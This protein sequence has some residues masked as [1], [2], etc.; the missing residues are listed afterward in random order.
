MAVKRCAER[1]FSAFAA[2]PIP[3]MAGYLSSFDI[4]KMISLVIILPH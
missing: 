3:G 2:A 1:I 4:T